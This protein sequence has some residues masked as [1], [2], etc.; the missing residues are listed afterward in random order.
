VLRVEALASRAGGPTRS[1]RRRGG[2]AVAPQGVETAHGGV[3]PG[4][5]RPGRPGGAHSGDGHSRLGGT[6]RGGGS[7]ATAATNE[8]AAVAAHLK[9]KC[10]RDPHCST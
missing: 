6:S 9:M 10:G 3:E 7:R 4:G 5:V 8:S 1:E 2:S